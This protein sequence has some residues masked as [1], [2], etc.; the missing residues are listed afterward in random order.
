MRTL[1]FEVSPADPVAF[2]AVALLLG[3][4]ALLAAYVPGR[5]AARIAPTTALRQ[6]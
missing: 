4:V 6:Q 1:L 2:G 3:G 5:R